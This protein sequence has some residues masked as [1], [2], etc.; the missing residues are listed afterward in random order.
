MAM[1]LFQ[2]NL[3][4][5]FRNFVKRRIN[6]TIIPFALGAYLQFHIQCVLMEKR[7]M[8]V[9]SCNPRTILWVL[10]CI[11]TTN[12]YQWNIYLPRENYLNL[13][14]VKFILGFNFLRWKGHTNLCHWCLGKIIKRQNVLARKSHR[15][16]AWN[17]RISKFFLSIHFTLHFILFDEHSD[18]NIFFFN[19]WGVYNEEDDS[20]PLRN[21]IVDSWSE[22]RALKAG[23]REKINILIGPRSPRLRIKKENRIIFPKTRCSDMF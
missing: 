1:C 8:N 3:L 4:C 6:K 11:H 12:F 13:L 10:S 20:Y 18:L 21:G 16:H 2:V 23:S 19:L 9:K 7:L 15:K 14:V 22:W 17:S 5:N